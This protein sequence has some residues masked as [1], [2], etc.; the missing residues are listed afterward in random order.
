[1][2]HVFKNDEIQ[3]IRGK[4]HLDP[5]YC[6]ECRFK[7][8]KIYVCIP[9]TVEEE[10]IQLPVKLDFYDR[11]STDSTKIGT[12]IGHLMVTYEVWK[13]LILVLHVLD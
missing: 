11:D 13:K 6:K 5:Q 4:K 10:D 1:M 8:H 9:G 2:L 3:A 12:L 7:E